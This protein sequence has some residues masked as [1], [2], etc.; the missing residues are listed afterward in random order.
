MRRSRRCTVRC[1]ARF[2]EDIT[3]NIQLPPVP[4]SNSVDL[5]PFTVSQIGCGTWAWGNQFL[6]GYNHEQDGE[7]RE[8]F[9][10]CVDKGV[11]LFDTGASYGT[12]KVLTYGTQGHSVVLFSW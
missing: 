7:L 10:L 2:F 8:V 3:K 6:W 11:N 5:G 1:V 4:G 12:G 9:E